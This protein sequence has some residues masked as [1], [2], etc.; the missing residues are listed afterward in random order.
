M[1]DTKKALE[2]LKNDENLD[3]EIIDI[4]LNDIEKNCQTNLSEDIIT[5]FQERYD[6]NTKSNN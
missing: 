2:E 3:Q 5:L 1:E 4:L 6:K